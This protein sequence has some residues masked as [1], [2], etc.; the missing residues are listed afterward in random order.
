MWS[1]GSVIPSYLLRGIFRFERTISSWI[2]RETIVIFILIGILI[3]TIPLHLF[4]V[5]DD[6]VQVTLDDLI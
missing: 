3:P 6:L 5:L 2:E 1:L 4:E